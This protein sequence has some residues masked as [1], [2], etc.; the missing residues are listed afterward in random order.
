MITR[1]NLSFSFD[2]GTGFWTLDLDL[3]S[4]IGSTEQYKC[5]SYTLLLVEQFCPIKILHLIRM[6]S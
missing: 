1:Y 3:D 6:K 5:I 4:D 2:I